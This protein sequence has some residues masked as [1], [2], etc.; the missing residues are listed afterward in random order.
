VRTIGLVRVRHPTHPSYVRVPRRFVA[1]EM[2]MDRGSVGRS[3]VASKKSGRA[4]RKPMVT[5]AEGRPQVVGSVVSFAGAGAGAGASSV[6]ASKSQAGGNVLCFLTSIVMSCMC[7]GRTAATLVSLRI[8]GL[9]MTHPCVISIFTFSRSLGR[10][11][12][13][14]VLD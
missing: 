2:E 11:N 14:R 8:R 5:I 1:G 3:T 4:G 7:C 13:S 6:S 12:T 9:T 10:A